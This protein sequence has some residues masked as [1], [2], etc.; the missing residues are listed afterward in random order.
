MR[1]GNVLGSSLCVCLSV[2]LCV[3]NA[4]TF[5]NLYFGNYMYQEGNYQ[6]S[7]NAVLPVLYC[8]MC[9]VIIVCASMANK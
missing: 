1:H 5:E 3:C 2:Y 8:D 9:V 4:I 6:C 7:L